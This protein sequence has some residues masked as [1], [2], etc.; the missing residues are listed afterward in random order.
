MKLWEE[1]LR[2]RPCRPGAITEKSA[3]IR[4]EI[5]ANTVVRGMSQN[6]PVTVS[7][8]AAPS[9]KDTV[10]ASVQAK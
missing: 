2:L 3:M 8:V 7:S 4:M 10:I 1:R 5:Q 6:V 9:L